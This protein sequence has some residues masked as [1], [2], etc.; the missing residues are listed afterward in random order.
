MF[1]HSCR[2]YAA[3]LNKQ[4]R[5]SSTKPHGTTRKGHECSCALLRVPYRAASWI[6]SFLS[7]ADSS[8]FRARRGAAARADAPPQTRGQQPTPTPAPPT[9]RRPAPPPLS[10]DGAAAYLRSCVFSRPPSP[11]PPAPHQ[12]IPHPPQAP[13]LHTPTPRF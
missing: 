8:A 12:R 2:A 13:T 9:A 11:P 4:T 3:S 6:N 7:L 10:P 1:T 5:L